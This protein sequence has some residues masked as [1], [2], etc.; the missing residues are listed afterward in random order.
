MKLWNHPHSLQRKTK[1]WDFPNRAVR[2]LNSA[3]RTVLESPK[4]GATGAGNL[5]FQPQPRLLFNLI[6]E[7]LAREI[8]QVREIKDIQTGWSKTLSICRWQNLQRAA[9]PLK[10][11]KLLDQNKEFNKV[12]GYKINTQK[13]VILSR[14]VRL[15]GLSV[16]LWAKGSP[17][18]FPVR[19]HAWVAGQVPSRGHSRG[20][21]TLMCLSLTFSFSSPLSKNE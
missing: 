2:S 10:I 12:E 20:N 21:H 15:S 17:G 18:Q 5:D 11:H 9:D 6:R 7:V 14:L 3:T 8:R 4:K 19:A 16:G 13:S 1:S